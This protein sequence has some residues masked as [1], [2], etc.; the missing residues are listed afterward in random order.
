MFSIYLHVGAFPID[1]EKPPTF[2]LNGGTLT[3]RDKTKNKQERERRGP[4]HKKTITTQLEKD[5]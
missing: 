5:R 3:R 1:D 2:F 4:Q